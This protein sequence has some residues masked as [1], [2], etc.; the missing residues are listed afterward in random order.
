LVQPAP[1]AEPAAVEPAAGRAPS[2]P[3]F[4]R[5][6]P[7]IAIA[8]VVVIAIA[9]AAAA[10]GGGGGGGSTTFHVPDAAA[11]PLAINSFFSGGTAELGTFEVVAGIPACDVDV[12][13]ATME[14]A[15][16]EW[17]PAI[18]V[19]YEKVIADLQREQVACAN[20]DQAAFVSANNDAVADL[21]AAGRA[22]DAA[23]CKVDDVFADT[24]TATCKN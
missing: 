19:P 3:W 7:L 9:A 12:A 20:L 2:K 8:A 18:K 24:T 11:G 6:V 16:T 10:G 4:K 1:A 5:P 22:W 14:S 13:L 21:A 15:D 17:P 23:D